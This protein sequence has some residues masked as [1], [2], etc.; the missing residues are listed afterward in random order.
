M[1]VVDGIWSTVCVWI[2]ARYFE[3]RTQNQT[4]QGRPTTIKMETDGTIKQ[5]GLLMNWN[6]LAQR[7]KDSKGYDTY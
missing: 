4:V 3:M 6:Y 5:D 1:L 2:C 7:K